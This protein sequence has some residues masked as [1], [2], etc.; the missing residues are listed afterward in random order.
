MEILDPYPRLPYY[1]IVSIVSNTLHPNN[2]DVLCI[3]NCLLIIPME[4]HLNLEVGMFFQIQGPILN[5]FPLLAT[6]ILNYTRV[7]RIP[8]DSSNA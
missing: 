8:Y 2:I 7:A 1:L 3:L 5:S 4:L 6:C